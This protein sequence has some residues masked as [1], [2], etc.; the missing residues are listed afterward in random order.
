MPAQSV[1]FFFIDGLGLATPHENNP[2]GFDLES[3]LSE[4]AE[5]ETWTSDHFSVMSRAGLLRR[6]IDARLGVDGLPQSGTGQAT[7]FS[8]VNCALLAGRHYGPYPHSTSRSVLASANL[9]H[10]VGPNHSVFANAYPERFFSMSKKR[11]RWSTTT[12]CCLE[13]DIRIRTMEDLASG[14]AIA[15]DLTGKGLA[16]IASSQV[17]PISQHESAQ[18]I[19][20]LCESNRLVVAE[21]F[22]SDKAGH[23]QNHEMAASC[24]NSIGAFF[25]GLMTQMDFSKMSIVVTS[26]HGNI[27]D[28]GTRSHTLNPVPLLVRGPA[29]AHFDD[30]RDLTGV[31]DAIA[32]SVS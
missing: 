18:R 16:G 31:A 24:L 20:N 27:E 10:K 17:I 11:D 32:A 30:V 28:L 9:Y 21:Y 25:S 14:E 26:D 23:K 13:A 7:I 8:G 12:R 15:A 19:V 6:G 3:G 2:L 1:F 4:L 22:H 5:C 29:A